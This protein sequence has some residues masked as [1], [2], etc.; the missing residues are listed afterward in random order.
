MKLHNAEII[1][2]YGFKPAQSKV[3]VKVSLGQV[4][5]G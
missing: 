5:L 2:K 1:Q 3:I 4:G